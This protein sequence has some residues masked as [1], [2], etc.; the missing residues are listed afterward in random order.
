MPSISSSPQEEVGQS[1]LSRHTGSWSD[2]RGEPS[3]ADAKRAS[4]L[5][6]SATTP[7]VTFASTIQSQSHMV[8][9][10]PHTSQPLL[11]I[12]AVDR[13]IVAQS[14]PHY[15]LD[16]RMPSSA[17]PRNAT[18]Y[19]TA[20]MTP[21]VLDWSVSGNPSTG[22]A[23]SG[24]PPLSFDGSTATRLQS[25]VPAAVERDSPIASPSSLGTPASATPSVPRSAQPAP[26]TT[27]DGLV[28][29]RLQS[30]GSI[31]RERVVPLSSPSSLGTPASA[32]PF[33]QR[34]AQPTVEAFSSLVSSKISEGY[35]L[36]SESCPV[37]HVPFVRH[38]CGLLFSVGTNRWY[39]LGSDRQLI[40]LPH[41]AALSS[42]LSPSSL[43]TSASATTTDGHISTRL[44]SFVPIASERAV[45]LISPSSLGTL[46]SAD[47]LDVASGA[48]P[49]SATD[50]AHRLPPTPLARRPTSPTT[51]SSLLAS[52]TLSNP[53]SAARLA[54]IQDEVVND[55]VQ[56]INAARVR[57]YPRSSSDRRDDLWPAG[58]CEVTPN[59]AEVIRYLIAECHMDLTAI[60]RLFIMFITTDFTLLIFQRYGPPL[61]EVV[62]EFEAGVCDVNALKDSL[63]G[64]HATFILDG[65]GMPSS[66]RLSFHQFL[67]LLISEEMVM[68]PMGDVSSLN[69][70][71][72]AEDAWD[73]IFD[74][75]LDICL[76][77]KSGVFVP[78]GPRASHHKSIYTSVMAVV[79]LSIDIYHAEAARRV[80]RARPPPR[81]PTPDVRDTARVDGVVLDDGRAAYERVPASAP[82]HRTPSVSFGLPSKCSTVG[83]TEAPPAVGPSTDSSHRDAYEL[84]VSHP[85]GAYRFHAHGTRATHAS[86]PG[87]EPIGGEPIA[88]GRAPAASP[89]PPPTFEPPTS[90]ADFDARVAA[91]VAVALRAHGASPPPASSTS[92]GRHSPLGEPPPS[93][94]RVDL[95]SLT[96]AAAVR[97]CLA[98]NFMSPPAW[99]GCPPP[100]GRV[101]GSTNSP[102]AWS[103][104]LHQVCVQLLKSRE[105]N[106][107]SQTFSNPVS[108]FEADVT[109]VL[110]DPDSYRLCR[111]SLHEALARLFL[112]KGVNDS[113]SKKEATQ[114]VMQQLE[115]ALP[116][117]PPKGCL[118][119][120]LEEVQRFLLHSMSH[121]DDTDDDADASL[122]Q[123]LHMLD[124]FYLSQT[125]SDPYNDFSS[126]HWLHSVPW[127]EYVVDLKRFA[128]RH[129]FFQRLNSSGHK[130]SAP[131]NMD[132]TQVFL[133][134]IV[135]TL[136]R[137]MSEDGNDSVAAELF[138][139]YSTT[140]NLN[141]QQLLDDLERRPKLKGAYRSPVRKIG[142]LAPAA[143]RRV[144][145]PSP[146]AA[147]AYTEHGAH[148][149]ADFAALRNNCERLQGEVAA[150][151]A[152]V[153]R[154][155][156]LAATS[157]SPR[158]P[159]PGD[160]LEQSQVDK[161]RPPL[162]DT[163]GI[164]V[165]F[166]AV[167]PG[168]QLP[169]FNPSKPLPTGMKQCLDVRRIQEAGL[170]T[171][172]DF[173]EPWN[174][175][176][177]NGLVSHTEC[178]MCPFAPWFSKITVC[179]EYKDLL[180]EYT[181]GKPPSRQNPS[182][183]HVAVY[184]YKAQCKW[185]KKHIELHVMTHPE[186]EWMKKP[187]EGPA[188]YASLVESHARQLA[189][190]NRPAPASPTRP[191]RLPAAPH[192]EQQVVDELEDA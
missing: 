27:I 51:E 120:S 8:G 174:I 39:A 21:A 77:P 33:V 72:V 68:I 155:K 74:R 149:P 192:P 165:F 114:Y 47:P 24:A 96:F 150:G 60:A 117:S 46:A 26:A 136:Q 62:S 168:A 137:C 140:L 111:P 130:G 32:N 16:S 123:F 176:H 175:N 189:L 126:M 188:F 98:E 185:L 151:K 163:A 49:S 56:A 92:P 89:P 180:K 58:R 67:V 90:T 152:E 100:P 53:P 71:G 116:K 15:G 190:N 154:L 76:D 86:A 44:Q 40:E 141:P 19:D 6:R 41:A 25:F 172:V 55:T 178:P 12:G 169:S 127:V 42:A 102:T 124:N 61:Q 104:H 69:P 20:Y 166:G 84:S 23:P 1:H 133:R 63:I 66:C 148:D 171:N 80:P 95:K 179:V 37:T 30:S 128:E 164:A 106:T 139:L 82:V 105:F 18:P 2:V 50:A 170:L 129:R 109:R 11:G 64:M 110:T 182:P 91:A 186:H 118:H 187:M 108:K 22:T 121:R 54:E 173:G 31:A 125:V 87:T 75:A 101:D 93:P 3:A 134:Q 132:A 157:S 161:T 135:Q 13:D 158:P 103:T 146:A 48:S 153:E 36:L 142:D 59:Q 147:A 43:G 122:M 83:R 29:T 107:R 99:Y 94:P 184:H 181:N 115:S 156:A 131:V 45:S 183:P 78:Y 112:T 88:S 79:R 162:E 97:E 65:H 35:T 38:P 4:T 10:S 73:T 145:L 85:A 28:P 34:I 177:K 191:G 159:R 138:T 17:S 167:A 119:Y 52:S 7:S 113:A 57:A 160:A 70:S 144:V 81:P 143:P 5:S 9:P 14:V